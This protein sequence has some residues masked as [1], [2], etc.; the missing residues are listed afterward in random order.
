MKFSKNLHVVAVVAAMMAPTAINQ[1]KFYITFENE[2]LIDQMALQAGPTASPTPEPTAT[3]KPTPEPTATPEPTPEPTATPEPTPEPTATPEPTPE[4]TATPEP[5]VYY[6]PENANR[7][8]TV[9]TIDLTVNVGQ[10]TAIQVDV[11]KRSMQ[12]PWDF[13]RHV[14][15]IPLYGRLSKRTTS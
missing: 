6:A 3:P 8:L 11:A 9:Q 7:S 4:P 5:V 10:Q 14:S 12:V 1:Q 13:K 2:E 15:N